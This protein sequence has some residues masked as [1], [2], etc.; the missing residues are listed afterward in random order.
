M[1]DPERIDRM[2]EKIRTLWKRNP[3][4]RLGQLIV[5]AANDGGNTTIPYYAEDDTVERGVDEGLRRL[6]L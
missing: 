1:R 4:L 2:L 3:D 6:E 5:N